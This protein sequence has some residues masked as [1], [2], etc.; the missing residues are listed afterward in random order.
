MVL[1]AYITLIGW[2]INMWFFF[3]I[4]WSQT[5]RFW[6]P[7]LQ[8]VTPFSFVERYQSLKIQTAGSS[9][10]MLVPNHI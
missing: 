2:E 10:K 9:S 5:E 7:L 4:K 6:E 8:N 1:L 3:Y